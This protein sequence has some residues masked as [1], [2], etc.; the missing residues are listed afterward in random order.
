MSS[1]RVPRSA[2]LRGA[3]RL[4]AEATVGVTDLVEAM[5]ERITRWPG[6][7]ATGGRDGDR[8]P[9][10]VKGR[11]RG[12]TGL[13]YQ[14]VRG[15]TRLAGGGVDALL[16]L[17][18][19]TL[20]TSAPSREREALVA[21]L[22]GV[23]GDHLVRSGNPLATPM[24]LRQNGEV[25][26]ALPPSCERALILI[27]GL[28]MNDL[29]WTRDG[30]DHGQAL[31]RDL[32]FTPLYLRY[33]SGV[34]ISTNGRELALRLEALL[35]D[36]APTLQRVV[37]VCHSMGGLLARS[38]LHHGVQAQHRWPQHVSDIVFLG[39]PHHGAPLERAGAWLDLILG[40][41]PYAA[42]FTRLT[43]LRSAGITDLRHASL[44]DEDWADAGAALRRSWRPAALP[45][46]GGVRCFAIAASLG[47]KGGDLK[48]RALGDGLVPLDSALGRHADPAR[49]LGFPKQNQWIGKAMNHMDLLS[50]GDVYAM[51]RRWLG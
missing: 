29:Q 36:A 49:A 11:T 24:T 40:A 33:N 44:L 3:V 2:D 31:Q 19:P 51:L 5:H 47:H 8:P 20:G 4:A 46:P 48:E 6:G 45:L 28:C 25:V 38:A 42:P 26:E 30:H 22:N 21:A 43:R 34:H 39:T 18:P 37:L 16:G 1:R 50:R 15:V 12:L 7:G 13:V 10:H 23:L 14:T 9:A 41:T 17:L 27:H 35:R 32:G